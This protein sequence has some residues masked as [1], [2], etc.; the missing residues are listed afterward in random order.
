MNF[1]SLSNI[2][3]TSLAVILPIC[4]T[5]VVLGV[6]A[7][8]MGPR[9]WN[10]YKGSQGA[11]KALQTGLDATAV[12]VNT[13][14]TGM[15]I[16]DNPRIGMELQ[17]QP[18]NGAPFQVRIEQTVSIVHMPMYQPGVN[19]QVKYDPADP[20][21]L[22]IVGVLGSA[23]PGGMPGYPGAAPAVTQAQ[24]DQWA[25]QTKA[26]QDSLS[27]GPTAPARVV[28]YQPA[29]FFVNGNNPAVNLQL[30]VQPP[31]GPKFVALTQCV[32]NASAV[33]KYQPGQ[34]VTVHYNPNDFTKVYMAHSGL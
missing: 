32:V 19:L 3:I 1:G 7:F 30:E 27:N 5:V 16:N 29:G 10:M 2:L 9:L 14:D 33:A 20:R 25:V 4:I 28:Q 24:A 12:I 31:T 13:W 22:A 23:Q 18:P 15:R 8:T 21:N 6:F 34:M 11:Q 26:L 17:V